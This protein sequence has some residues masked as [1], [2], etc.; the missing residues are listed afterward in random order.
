MGIKTNLAHSSHS[1]WKLLA[2]RASKRALRREQFRCFYF[3]D[4]LCKS[5]AAGAGGVRRAARENNSFARG[6]RISILEIKSQSAD[7]NASAIRYRRQE[8]KP[9]VRAGSSA[10]VNDEKQARS[11][12]VTF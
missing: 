6:A 2:T 3:C 7:P 12:K 8:R 9:Q 5:E 10:K 11:Q 1:T 4:E